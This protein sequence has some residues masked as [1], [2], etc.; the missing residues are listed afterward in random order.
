M[1]D[2]DNY[3]DGES[4]LDESVINVIDIYKNNKY[5]QMNNKS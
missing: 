4:V 2:P 1:L 3:D 5:P